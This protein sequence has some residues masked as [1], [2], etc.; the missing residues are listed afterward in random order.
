MS[1]LFPQRRLRVVHQPAE[2]KETFE[3]ARASDQFENWRA[4]KWTDDDVRM[5][6]RAESC[7]PQSASRCISS[8]PRS[9]S[10]ERSCRAEAR[11]SSSTSTHTR[12]SIEAAAAAAAWLRVEA[13]SAHCVSIALAALRAATAKA[14]RARG[15]VAK[16][17]T[18][19][20]SPRKMCDSRGV[21][22]SGR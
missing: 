1:C 22:R 9:T 15:R 4:S 6:L 13:L 8:E 3:S 11:D 2:E 16:R 5:A 20:I 12:F 10:S 19:T 21:E 17:K 18:I 14:R 7:T